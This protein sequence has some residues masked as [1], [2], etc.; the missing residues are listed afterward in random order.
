LCANA[1]LINEKSTF[2]DVLKDIGNGAYAKIQNKIKKEKKYALK[3]IIYNH[4]Y[5]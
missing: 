3:V 2:F 4:F 5:I 1:P